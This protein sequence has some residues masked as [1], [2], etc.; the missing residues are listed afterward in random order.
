M[1]AFNH[2]LRTLGHWRKLC[3]KLPNLNRIQDGTADFR[4]LLG[5]A[6]EQ[7]Q[8]LDQDL[9]R[10]PGVGGVLGGFE[11]GVTHATLLLGKLLQELDQP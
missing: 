9:L 3:E 5:Q 2:K 10:E 6:I 8:L 11:E 4:S 1:R 7:L